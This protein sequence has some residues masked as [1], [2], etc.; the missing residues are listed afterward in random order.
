[1]IDKVREMKNKPMFG[2]RKKWHYIDVVRVNHIEEISEL[3]VEKSGSKLG[4]PAF[5]AAFQPALREF[6]KTLS[7]E[8]RI[9][10]KS[11]AIKWTEES[12]PRSEQYR[13]VRFSYSRILE[14]SNS[15][16][17]ACSRNIACA[18]F[19]NSL[20]QYFRSTVCAL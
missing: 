19:A 8:V 11:D 20:R 1:M 15:T 7:E 2:M 3:A 12:P 13:Y 6:E 10:Y 14:M 16:E 9:Q 18:H 4:S 5:L 17:Q